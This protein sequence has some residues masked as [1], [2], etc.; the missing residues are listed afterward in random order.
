ML[1]LLSEIA[2]FLRSAMGI[3][4]ANRKNRCDFGALSFSTEHRNEQ[5]QRELG[6]ELAVDSLI[7]RHGFGRGFPW[8]TARILFQKLAWIWREFFEPFFPC[9]KKIHA[10][11]TPPK[12]PKSTPLS[13]TFFPMVSLGAWPGLRSCF[14]M[15]VFLC[16]STKSCKLTISVL[17]TSSG[18]TTEHRFND[19]HF[20]AKIHARF[21]L[22]LRSPNF[23]GSSG[24]LAHRMLE[25][26]PV[27]LNGLKLPH[28]TQK[29]TEVLPK[30]F[31]F[32]NSSTQITEFNSQNNSVRDSVIL[33]SHFLPRTSNSRNNSVR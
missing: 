28:Y 32:G 5:A 26:Y 10:K 11:S 27:S 33:C 19:S 6:W 2:R 7:L 24:C 12:I 18:T 4:I 30:R 8:R 13:E 29:I 20:Q 22:C 9:P 1:S 16:R 15:Q 14:W 23:S 3:A 17:G 25:C 21:P 31:R